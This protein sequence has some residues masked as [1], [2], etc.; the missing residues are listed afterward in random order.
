MLPERLDAIVRGLAFVEVDAVGRQ[1]APLR[2]AGALDCAKLD[3]ET[4]VGR[5]GRAFGHRFSSGALEIPAADAYAERLRAAGVEPDAE[6]AA[7]R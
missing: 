3:D 7:A 2:A 1:R 6:R 4:V 5:H